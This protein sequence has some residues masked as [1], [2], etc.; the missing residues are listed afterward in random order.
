MEIS[1]ELLDE[2]IKYMEYLK[3][4]GQE[5]KGWAM[6]VGEYKGYKLR[7]ELKLEDDN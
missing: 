7:L 4:G 6:D 3:S 2:M 5:I 1:N